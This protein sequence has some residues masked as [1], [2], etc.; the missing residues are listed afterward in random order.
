MKFRNIKRISLVLALLIC[1]SALL[2]SCGA[3]PVK[4]TEE[5]AAV[6][7]TIGKYEVRYEE[8]RYLVL[9]HKKDMSLKYGESI[10]T[11]SAKLEEYKAELWNRVNDTIVSDYYAVQAMA[12]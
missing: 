9:N 7:G 10:W 5:E 1:L 3:K 2:S 8:L 4:S 11:D 12:D 6:V